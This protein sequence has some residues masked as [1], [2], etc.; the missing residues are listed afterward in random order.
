MTNPY[1]NFLNFSNRQLSVEMKGCLNLNSLILYNLEIEI[2]N[3]TLQNIKLLESGFIEKSFIDK[4]YAKSIYSL[5]NKKCS[6]SKYIDNT[7]NVNDLIYTFDFNTFNSDIINK[8]FIF[9]FEVDSNFNEQTNPDPNVKPQSHFSKLRKNNYFI[10]N[11][12]YQLYSSN[13]SNYFTFVKENNKEKFIEIDCIKC[14]YLVD[15][16]NKINLI[17]I[18]ELKEIDILSNN[19][20][21]S[22]L[23]EN[24]N[25][26]LSKSKFYVKIEIEFE[27]IDNTN[28]TFSNDF[29]I[30]ICSSYN[31]CMFKDICKINLSNKL[32]ILECY[33]KY[34]DYNSFENNI[35]DSII[36]IT[37]KIKNK[38]DKY[39]ILLNSNF[40]GK[41]MYNNSVCVNYNTHF[42]TLLS[43]KIIF[44]LF[45]IS[46]YIYKLSSNEYDST[47]NMIYFNNLNVS[48]LDTGKGKYTI[49]KNNIVVFDN[50]DNNN[51]NILNIIGTELNFE[52]SKNN[53]LH[54]NNCLLMTKETYK[55]IIN[56]SSSNFNIQ[57]N[58]SSNFQI[59]TEEIT[60]K[61]KEILKNKQNNNYSQNLIT[62]LYIILGGVILIIIII[63]SIFLIYRNCKRNRSY[64]II[65]S[66]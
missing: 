51:T 32:K 56:D 6:W 2:N 61:D 42:K 39:L 18:S 17:R 41:L 65:R 50:I 11:K 25:I 26:L 9:N 63:I 19:I 37:D 8:L 53:K 33:I 20:A 58:Q 36:Y 3:S 66:N 29:E 13:Y 59:N 48:S 15:F 27:S 4:S 34:F 38:T 60:N 44:N 64:R 10:Y 16:S 7:I 55:F 47:T 43:N 45:K 24:W 52:Y 40:K 21:V 12:D 22:F 14:Y 57:S 5:K 54:V 1:I 31:I 62:Q 46:N 49:Q 28:D 30:K 35:I 23:V